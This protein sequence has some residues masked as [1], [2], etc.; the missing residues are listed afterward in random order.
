MDE[1]RFIEKREDLGGALGKPPSGNPTLNSRRCC[2]PFLIKKLL[3][4]SAAGTIV[5]RQQQQYGL[6]YNE[7]AK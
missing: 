3:E 4:V 5:D 7:T 1:C 2:I 6:R